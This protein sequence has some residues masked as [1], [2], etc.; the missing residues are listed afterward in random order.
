LTATA[1]LRRGVVLT[2]LWSSL[3]ETERGGLYE[4]MG[5]SLPVGCV[6]RVAEVAASSLY[7]MDNGYSTG[8]VIK[9]DGGAVLA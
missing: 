3:Y 2:D 9:I 8:S 4:T 6:G 7:L 5:E 1:N